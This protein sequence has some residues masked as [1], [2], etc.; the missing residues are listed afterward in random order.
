MAR[1]PRQSE[2]L[3]REQYV[4][5]KSILDQLRGVF[6]WPPEVLFVVMLLS[7]YGGAFYFRVA[8]LTML[9]GR[10]NEPHGSRPQDGRSR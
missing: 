9:K 3:G 10:G 6:H 7:F 5:V 8:A 1:S 4:A 2:Y